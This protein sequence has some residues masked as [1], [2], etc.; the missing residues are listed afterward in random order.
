M[1]E[2]GDLLVSLDNIDKQFPF[3]KAVDSGR[4]HLEKGEIHA[5]RGENGAG[6]STLR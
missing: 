3:V 6:K 2:T 5:L 4:F 1:T